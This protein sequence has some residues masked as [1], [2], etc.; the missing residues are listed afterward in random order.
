MLLTIDRPTHLFLA[1]CVP[2]PDTD[3]SIPALPGMPEVPHQVHVHG[4]AIEDFM[5]ARYAG[6]THEYPPSLTFQAVAH[7]ERRRKSLRNVTRRWVLPAV[8]QAFASADWTIFWTTTVLAN[9]G[10]GVW[11]DHTHVLDALADWTRDMAAVWMD[12]HG[13]AHSSPRDVETARVLDSALADNGEEWTNFVGLGG[14]VE[15]QP[16]APVVPDGPSPVTWRKWD[17]CPG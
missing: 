8:E 13:A 5:E 4:F 15:D 9:S 12:P 11:V 6:H 2:S 17:T 10:R 3:R 16:P 14:F 1:T 7:V